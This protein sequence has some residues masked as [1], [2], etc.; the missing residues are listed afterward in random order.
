MRAH[1]GPGWLDAAAMPLPEPGLYD[2]AETH[3][4]LLR[5]PAGELRVRHHAFPGL[6]LYD[7]HL[8]A[9]EP[10]EVRPRSLTDDPLVGMQVALSGN[11]TLHLPDGRDTAIARGRGGFFRM[12]GD[13]ARFRSGAGE[14]HLVGA[15]AELPL[16]ARWFGPRIPA[17]LRP[18]LHDRSLPGQLTALPVPAVEAAA[19]AM[20]HLPCHGALRRMMLEGI[21]LQM[22]AGFLDT[23]CGSGVHEPAMAS[24]EQRAA[25][26]AHARLLED[27]RA[28]PAA[29]ELAREVGLSP[30]RL[31]RAFRELYGGSVFAVLRRERLEHALLALRAGD[32]PVKTIAWYAGYD[33]VA[34][35]SHAFQARF[36]VAPSAVRSRRRP[37][38]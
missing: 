17:A 9:T 21:A 13:G 31:D 26:E 18:Y 24:R 28:P 35:F 27:M 19:A 7:S 8:I 2:P 16:L 32:L 30:R 5:T 12:Q 15:I 3:G 29:T 11:T 23:V 37:T 36:G 22:V 4:A 34:S 33:H 6:R 38:H 10:M 1:R 25:R 20:Q 14:L